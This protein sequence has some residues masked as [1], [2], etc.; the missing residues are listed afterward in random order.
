MPDSEGKLHRAKHNTSVIIANNPM[1]L[2]L[3]DKWFYV[4]GIPAYIH[5]D[6]GQSFDNEIMSHMLCMGLSN[7]P[8]HYTICME[9]LLLK[10]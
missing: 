8:P 1:D 3:V 4:Y 10:H 6:K 5:S 7:L 9:L 2:V